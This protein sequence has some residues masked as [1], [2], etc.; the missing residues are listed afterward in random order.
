M[1]F[2]YENIHVMNNFTNN[3]RP[4]L[5]SLF[6]AAVVFMSSCVGPE[7]PPGPP[8]FDGLDGRNGQDGLSAYSVTYSMTAND[9]QANGAPGD[10]GYFLFL[11]IDV[12]EITFNIVE[13][14]LVLAYYREQEDDPWIAL[15]Y[16]FISH[17][18][19]T[20]Y[21]ETLDFI[22]AQQYFS[23]KSQATDREATPFEGFVRIVV[24]DAI[25]LGK[26]EIDLRDYDQ[27]AAYYGLKE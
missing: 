27:V 9:W 13:S 2:H 21:I 26:T 4:V 7:G 3:Q 20:N 15:P 10:E 11:D 24:A 17:D 6:L 19:S 8:G 16:T 5:F 1:N 22:Y 23:L 14:G 18:P 25:P 12:P